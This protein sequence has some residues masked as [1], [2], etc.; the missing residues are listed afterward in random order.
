[1]ARFEH[2]T[3]STTNGLVSAL[4]RP[5][6]DATYERNVRARRAVG[7][8]SDATVHEAASPRRQ[9]LTLAE[10]LPRVLVGDRDKNARGG[11][12]NSDGNSTTTCFKVILIYPTY[13]ERPTLPP[14]VSCFVS[15]CFYINWRRRTA[16]PRVERT[17]S[18]FCGLR[19][20]FREI[21]YRDVRA[22]PSSVTTSRGRSPQ[23]ALTVEVVTDC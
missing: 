14:L 18:L 17:P 19:Q 23:H 4:S 11:R 7:M 1:M 8:G 21:S 15:Y 12:R 3:T 16:D 2:S 22:L 5:S 9:R 10:R 6:T 20:D 13:L